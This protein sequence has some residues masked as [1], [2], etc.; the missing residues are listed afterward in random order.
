MTTDD[1]HLVIVDYMLLSGWQRAAQGPSGELW[2]RGDAEAVV[3]RSL[4]VGSSPWNR[5]ASALAAADDEP[6][7][8]VIAKWYDLLA[9][10][11]LPVT[12]KATPRPRATPGRVELEVRLEGIT[13]VEHQTGAYDF[14]RFVMRTADSVKE[15]VKSSRGIRHHSRDLLVAGGPRK[16]SVKVI[17]REPN[18][19]D[20]TALLPDA[21]ETAEGQALV[22]MAGVFGAA[23]V[24][25]EAPDA[26]GLR[27]HLAPLQVGA[28]QSMARLADTLLDGGWVLTGTIRRGDEEAH[29]QLGPYAAKV[30]ST[31]SREGFEEQKT[32][33]V[34]G[35]LDGWVWSASELTM[36]TDDRGTI[37]VSVPMPLQSIVAELHAERDTRVVARVNVYSRMAVGTRHAVHVTYS[38]ASIEREAQPTLL[39]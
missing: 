3:P 2:T 1:A 38:L 18:R 39:D 10:A 35:T 32:E 7:E 29:V 21:P 15:L 14:G 33:P 27:S 24:A 6:P 12:S 22:F 13:V 8:D 11:R 9:N 4:E 17:F 36:I 20:Q 37:R 25:A 31:T 34:S 30:L 5:L 19:T 26:D 23:E 16:G 28:R